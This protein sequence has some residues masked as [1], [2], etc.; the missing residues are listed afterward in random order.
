MFTQKVVSQQSKKVS[1]LPELFMH[2][3]VHQ[4]D[5]WACSTLSDVVEICGMVHRLHEKLRNTTDVAL[6]LKGVR[7]AKN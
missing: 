5:R 4:W 2:D 7:N 6:K 3:G 1:L